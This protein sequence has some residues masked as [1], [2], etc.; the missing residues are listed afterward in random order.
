MGTY[1]L[2]EDLCNPNITTDLGCKEGKCEKERRGLCALPP[3]K[4]P[5]TV[6]GIKL[7]KMK[8]IKIEIGGFTFSFLRLATPALP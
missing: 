4:Q 6:V 2:T 8:K 7:H 1:F 3:V 5:R